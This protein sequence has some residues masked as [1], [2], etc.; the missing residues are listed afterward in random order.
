MDTTYIKV[1]AH[2]TGALKKKGYQSIGKSRG[3]NTTKIH[4]VVAN[5]SLP[6]VRSLS[7]GCAAD[8]PEGQK[9]MEAIPQDICHGKPLLMD[10]TYKGNTRRKRC[11][12]MRVM[13]HSGFIRCGVM[14]GA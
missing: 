5:A 3:G 1:H 13:M 12:Q 14:N 10:K 11:W 9:L 2:G 7:S 4:V 6:I 8:D